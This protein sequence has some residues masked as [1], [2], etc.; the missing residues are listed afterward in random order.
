M[1]ALREVTGDKVLGTVV[2]IVA[3]RVRTVDYAGSHFSAPAHAS[4]Y[5][6]N[7]LAAGLEEL[8]NDRERE[9]CM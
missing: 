7:V 5:L 6:L 2:P 1:L 3:R 9:H 8:A 4:E